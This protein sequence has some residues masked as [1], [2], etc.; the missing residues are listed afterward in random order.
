ML[1]W[2]PVLTVCFRPR[3]T[4]C[5]Y[6]MWLFVYVW[7][8]ACVAQVLLRLA[9]VLKLRVWGL[10]KPISSQQHRQEQY[11]KNTQYLNNIGFLHTLSAKSLRHQAK[12]YLPPAQKYPETSSSQRFLPDSKYYQACFYEL[13]SMLWSVGSLLRSVVRYGQWTWDS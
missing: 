4:T 1:A 3:P 12:A 8:F 9:G 2:T 13:H 7:S 10:C 11:N 5:M 6:C